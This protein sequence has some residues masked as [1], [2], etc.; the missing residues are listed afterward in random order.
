MAMNEHARQ[1]VA[2]MVIK[3]P[4]RLPVASE[5]HSDLILN[6]VVLITYIPLLP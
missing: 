2:K 6:S 1:K 4:L 3:R 5:V